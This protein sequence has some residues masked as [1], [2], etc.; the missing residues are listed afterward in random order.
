M[1]SSRR[2]GRTYDRLLRLYPADYRHRFGEGMRYA[3]QQDHVA[4]RHAGPFA[5][6]RFWLALLWHTS[7]GAVLARWPRLD[8]ADRA[9]AVL[10]PHRRPSMRSPFALDLR[11]AWRA[12][13]AAPLVTGVALLSLGLGIGAN[14]ALFSIVDSLMLKTLPVRA[15][16]QL[17]L[18]DD[19]T[20]TNPIWESIR[21]RKTDIAEGM[22]AWST[23]RFNLTERGEAEYVNGL[24]ASGEMFDVLGVPAFLGRTLTEADDTRGGGPEGAAAMLGYHF[25]QQRFG[26]ATDVLGQSLTIGGAVYTIVGVTPPSFFGPE[27]GQR[28]DVVC[29]IGTEPLQRG[30]SSVLDA[31]SNWW[32]RIMARLRP[33][34]SPEDAA[35]R[36]NGLRGAIKEETT[37]QAWLDEARARY[38]DTAFT[39]VPAAAGTSGLRSRYETPLTALMVV[40]GVVLLIACGNIANLLLA[41][42]AA[43]RHEFS[44]RLALGASRARLARQLLAESLL[45]AGAGALL[46]LAFARW[47]GPLLVR[48]IAAG[49]QSTSLDLSIDW[50]VAAFAFAVAGGTAVI[51]GVA[52]ALRASRVSPNDALKSQGRGVAGDGTLSFRHALVVVQ[53]AL[54]LALVVAAA[55]F[56]QTFA[57]LA[58]LDVGFDREPLLVVSANLP[59]G[60]S[61]PYESFVRLRDA[62]AAVPGVAAATASF[63]TPVSGSAWNTQIQVPDGPELPDRQRLPMVNYVMPGWFATYGTTVLRGRDFDD[64]DRTGA[65]DV[66]IVNETFVRRFFPEREPL[67]A[68]VV[69]PAFRA[70]D[71]ERS[72]QIVGVVRDAVY[73]GLRED[74]PPTMYLPMAQFGDARGGTSMTVRASAGPPAALASGVVAALTREEPRLILS[75]RLL[76]E[77]IDASLAQERL[78]AMLSGFFGALALGLAA[79]GLYG[80]TAYSVNQRRREIGVRLA[81]GAEPASVVG[82]VMGLAVRLVAAGIAAG[83]VLSLWAA[84]YV[85]SLLFGLPARDPGTFI[86]AAVVLAIAG[87]AAGWLPARRAARLDPAVVLRDG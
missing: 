20:W 32:L 59:S 19:G 18:L 50:R 51:F 16:E 82:M 34:Q 64:R 52:P 85:G 44:V 22:F 86:G 2:A 76:S 42:A 57:R 33:D 68:R 8:W 80:V 40:V 21:D 83:A 55:L 56:T 70:D 9:T 27:V 3:F 37:P 58:T 73:R 39:L 26:G 38:L 65:P 72:Y 60:E 14:T 87:A 17:V 10:V 61:A 31:R 45:L 53:V 7:V 43:R 63:I 6:A 66:V 12:L 28:F 54:S 41:R 78:V 5:L 35:A 81:L 48:Q 84:S 24:W 71:A 75:I 1:T 79:L 49:A 4:A 30:A 77:R 25:W 29:P 69:E 36:L 62:V 23:D 46:G 67:G 13:R 47:T 15:P 74:V 11:D